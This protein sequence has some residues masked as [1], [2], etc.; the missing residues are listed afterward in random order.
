MIT[1]K[2][3]KMHIGRW[4]TSKRQEMCVEEGKEEEGRRGKVKGRRRIIEK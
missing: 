1:R 2:L 4:H 3:V